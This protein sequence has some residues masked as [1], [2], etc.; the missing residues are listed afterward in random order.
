M[1]RC[2][3]FRGRG[4]GNASVRILCEGCTLVW[5][6]QGGIGDELGT[7]NLRRTAAGELST[8]K[9]TAR[10]ASA[11]PSLIIVPSH[12][13]ST[14][15]P[16]RQC[17]VTQSMTVNDLLVLSISSSASSPLC[18]PL[19]FIFPSRAA[20]VCVVSVMAPNMLS[21][22]QRMRST[23]AADSV[24][25]CRQTIV[26]VVRPAYSFRSS[27]AM[28]LI[29]KSFW[30]STPEMRLGCWLS[31]W[32]PLSSPSVLYGRGGGIEA[33]LPTTLAILSVLNG[34]RSSSQFAG[35]NILVG[36]AFA[37]LKLSSFD[38]SLVILPFS[39]CTRICG[40]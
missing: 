29:L 28:R 8:E 12:S 2:R 19:P 11:I 10:T 24:R 1:W 40:T 26:V 37:A 20:S 9:R 25:C 27:G 17:T 4:S 5:S 6:F 13:T 34:M 21:R 3:R 23:P 14:R 30:M 15:P 22:A 32:S 39:P 38:L 31:N 7:W 36:V 35:E 33:S 18:T 16:D